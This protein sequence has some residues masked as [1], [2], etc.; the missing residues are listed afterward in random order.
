MKYKWLNKRNNKKLI[1]FFNGW[2]MDEKIVNNL[3]YS[4]FDVLMFYNYTDFAIEK[5]NFSYYETKILIAWSLGVFVCNLFY[6][7]FKDFDSFIAINGTQK[8]IDDDYGIPKKI[9]DLTVDNFN[10]LSS[11]KFMKKISSNVDI[12]EYCSRS[13]DELKAELISIRDLK[14]DNLFKF[15]KAYVSLKDR[16]IPAQNQL[17]YWKKEGV[18]VIKL[19]N[20]HYIF[21]E[22]SSW[23]DFL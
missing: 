4:D 6:E 17:N 3:E 10:E 18:D 1:V 22:F 23:S 11:L 14:T 5:F 8:P 9:Y 19:E 20:M 13:T 2:G 15:N 12:K 16:I 21:H 7:E